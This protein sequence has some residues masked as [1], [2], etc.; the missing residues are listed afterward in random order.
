MSEQRIRR[1]GFTEVGPVCVPFYSEISL[2]DANDLRNAI[3]WDFFN[4]FP[5]KTPYLSDTSDKTTFGKNFSSPLHDSAIH[6]MPNIF[7]GASLNHISSDTWRMIL[8][9]TKTKRVDWNNSPQRIETRLMMHVYKDQLVEAVRKV[10]VIRGVGELTVESIENQIDENT[11]TGYIA[12]QRREYEQYIIPEDCERAKV[13][14][15]RAV[16]R[17]KVL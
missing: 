13:Y 1:D 12:L 14:M 2:D 8:M 16:K 17:A 9:Y 15:H 3:V 5:A 7:F 10:R 11:D 6:E 4:E